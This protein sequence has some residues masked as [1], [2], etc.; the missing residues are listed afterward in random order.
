MTANLKRV[1]NKFFKL[2]YYKLFGVKKKIIRNSSI[3][4]TRLQAYLLLSISK[5]DISLY[6]QL[7]PENFQKNLINE[8]LD[9]R[10]LNHLGHLLF[11]AGKIE[12]ACEA[13]VHLSQ[14]CLDEIPLEFQLQVLRYSGITSFLLGKIR[15]AN[16]YWA[17][18]G[19]LRRSILGIENGPVYRILGTGWFAAIGHVAMLDFYLKFNK[20]YRKENVR[21]VAA[22]D[23][24]SIPGKYLCERFG[25]IGIEFISPRELQADYDLWAIYNNKPRWQALTSDYQ[26]ALIDDFWEYEFPD[27]EIWGYTHASHKIQREWELQN[28]PPLMTITALERKFTED[29]LE[30]LGVP[31]DAWYVCLHVRE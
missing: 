25:E 30:L 2:I 19:K 14:N 10:T 20:L 5:I 13:F 12:I 11:S 28:H 27:G 15:Q 18:A 26:S 9:A 3:D 29:T 24:N 31:K 4:N 1:N 17:L 6:E 21:V 7:T 8:K 23:I 22:I 16:Y